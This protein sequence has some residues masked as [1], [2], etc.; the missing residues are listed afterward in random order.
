MSLH[1]TSTNLVIKRH[2]KFEKKLP[3]KN[4]GFGR[5]AKLAKKT[6]KDPIEKE[7]EPDIR[8]SPI[9][10]KNLVLFS[11]LLEKFCKSKNFVNHFVEASISI[12]SA[13]IV[14]KF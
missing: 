3:L 11:T 12:F 6:K 7:H 4:G 8:I 2:Q 9:S 5:Y 14:R 13:E 1:V 10:S